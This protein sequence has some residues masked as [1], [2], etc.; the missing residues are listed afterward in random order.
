VQLFL[1]EFYL[2]ALCALLFFNKCNCKKAVLQQYRSELLSLCSFSITL[3]SIMY[4]FQ[5]FMGKSDP[6]LEFSRQMPD[7]KLQVVHRTEV[8]HTDFFLY[9]HDNMIFV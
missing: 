6:Y 9:H 7:G 1:I 3:R 4:Y 8:Q 2:F 5:D